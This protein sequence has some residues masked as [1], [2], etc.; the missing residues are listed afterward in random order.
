MALSATDVAIGNRLVQK[1]LITLA[2][3]DETRT[4]AEAWN[5]S[6]IDVLLTRTWARPLE[7]YRTVAE[8]F[9]LPFVNLIDEPPDDALLDP[10]DHDDCA[11]NLVLPWR[12]VNGRL[13]IATA[14]PGP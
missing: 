1:R 12:R 13:Q 5:V 10:A 2:Q 3:L 4:R 11:R 9:D 6:L 14:R 7:L 8:H